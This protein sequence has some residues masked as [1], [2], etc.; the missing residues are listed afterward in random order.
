M[1]SMMVV[2]GGTGRAAR[3]RMTRT[4][5]EEGIVNGAFE[6]RTNLSARPPRRVPVGDV[7]GERVGVVE[8]EGE[9]AGGCAAA[10]AQAA[11]V[12]ALL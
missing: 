3:R 9:P 6:R 5:E 11:E 1:R 8:G 10:L 2:R 12:D 4:N 7:H